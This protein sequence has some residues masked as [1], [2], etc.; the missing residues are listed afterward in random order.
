MHDSVSFAAFWSKLQKQPFFST[1]NNKW[2][3]KKEKK[4]TLINP[5][6]MKNL[7]QQTV[8]HSGPDF[9]VATKSAFKGDIT[10]IVTA[11]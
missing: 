5:V 3:E 1:G 8:H 7:L 10:Y 11:Y 2:N 6:K 4:K 9:G